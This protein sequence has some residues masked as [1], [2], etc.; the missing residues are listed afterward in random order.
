MPETF[1]LHLKSEPQF[2][3]RSQESDRMVEEINL[4]NNCVSFI[5]F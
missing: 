3:K 5:K 1:T 4:F 2:A